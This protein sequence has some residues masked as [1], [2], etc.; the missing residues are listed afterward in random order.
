AAVPGPYQIRPYFDGRCLRTVTNIPAGRALTAIIRL[1]TEI[2]RSGTESSDETSAWDYFFSQAETVAGSDADVSLAFF[3]GAVP[4]PGYFRNLREDNLTV[5]RLARAALET[6]AGYYQEL[7]GRILPGHKCKRIAF[8]GGIAQKSALL[9]RL[10]QERIGLPSRLTSS[11]EDS[12]L[13]LMVLGRVIAGLNHD[14]AS[15]SQAAAMLLNSS[16]E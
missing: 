6:M 4:G 13:G 15:A 10:T 1:L 12:L 8:S 2:P 9:R 16:V 5:G 7:S 14:V 3:P 11:T